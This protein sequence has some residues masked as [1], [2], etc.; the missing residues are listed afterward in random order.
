MTLMLASVNGPTEAEIALVEGADIIDLK[1]PNKGAFGAVDLSI[2]E[3]TVKIVAGR[4]RISAVS[5]ELPMDPPVLAEAATA[6]AA[7]G[8]DFVKV[9]FFPSERATA[10]I[11]ALAPVAERT[12]LIAVCFADLGID[13]TLLKP[14][15]K[16]G[17]AGAMLDTATKTS[18]RLIDYMAIPEL[19]GFIQACRREKLLAGLA[20]ALEAPDVAR[21]LLLRPDFLGFRGALCSD[22][23][24]SSSISA[25]NVRLIRDLIPRLDTPGNPADNRKVDWRFLAARGYSLGD[26]AKPATDRVFVHD[27]TLPV[28]IGAYDYERNLTQNVRFNID[29]D[30]R[31]SSRQAE[32]MRDVF[33]YDVIVDA[34]KLILARGHV[35]L[36]ET[37]AEQIADAVLAYPRVISVRV[38]VEKLDIIDGRVGVEIARERAAQSAAGS[39]RPPAS[40]VSSLKAGF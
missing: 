13:P 39:R 17:F 26:E 27:L 6:L 5:G 29:A 35:A 37:L 14:M 31:R 16:A 23:S 12:K 38:R 11:A 7:T 20:G 8:V 40:E 28:S 19:D 21:L 34:I 9:A 10:C 4:R 2:V 1:D 32:D 36:V 25:G 3:D 22:R 33:S 24:R 15:A 30:V 18:L